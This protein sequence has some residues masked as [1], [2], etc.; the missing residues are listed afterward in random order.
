MVV[1]GDACPATSRLTTSSGTPA[2]SKVGDAAPAELVGTGHPYTGLAAG[3]RDD[4][5]HLLLA[6]GVAL[7]G[8]EH[9][10]VRLGVGQRPVK[11][12]VAQQLPV[13]R[14]GRHPSTLAAAEV[15]H[16]LLH[17]QANVRPSRG[18]DDADAL[19]MAAQ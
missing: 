15:D 11:D 12:E 6:Q 10:R 5:V 17:V 3:L 4:A 2:C 9:H 1:T 14:Q 16:W 7:L 18:A 13:N 19:E 8:A